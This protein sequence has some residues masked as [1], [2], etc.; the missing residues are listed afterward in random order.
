MKGYIN[1]YELTKMLIHR[2]PQQ[3]G[4][5]Q[6]EYWTLVKLAYFYPTIHPSM[7]TLE[8][9]IGSDRRNVKKYI[10]GL[11]EKGYIKEVIPRRDIGTHINQ[12]VLDAEKIAGRKLTAKIE[13]QLDKEVLLTGYVSDDGTVYKN[14]TDWY[15]EQAALSKA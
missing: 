5:T 9:M 12:F 14:K 2:S 13:K 4:L 11:V 3:L 1:S 7:L 8:E 10:N 6:S 15:R